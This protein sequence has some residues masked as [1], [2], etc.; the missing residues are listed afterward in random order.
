MIKTIAGG[1]VALALTLS[2]GAGVANAADDRP[3]RGT[4]EC[5]NLVNGQADVKAARSDVQLATATLNTDLRQVPIVDAT[6]AVDRQVLADAQAHLRVVVDNVT[7]SLCRK[8]TVVVK[9]TTVPP[10]DAPPVMVRPGPTTVVERHD[11]TVVPRSTTTVVDR[12]VPTADNGSV[13]VT[14]GSQ[15]SSVPEG[16][17]STGEA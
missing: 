7:T 2:V 4:Q 13:A 3:V 12:V 11:T 17:A 15:V 14:S 1:A 9:P 5:V 6:V 16:S 8:G 10:V